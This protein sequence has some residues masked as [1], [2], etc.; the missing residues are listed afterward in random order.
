[1]RLLV[2]TV[3]LMLAA[4]SSATAEE[5]RGG[6]GPTIPQATGDPHPEGNDYMRRNHMKMMRHDRDLT[7]Y[8]GIR[9]AHASIAACFDCH[10]VKDEE[11]IP[12][13][14][15]DERHFCRTCHDFAAVRIDCFDCHRSTPEGVDEP[16][17]HAGRLSVPGREADDSAVL[18]AY[19]DG[20]QTAKTEAQQ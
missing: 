7:M 20:L 8:D 16:E 19:L 9:P 2:L 15:A 17:I 4:V 18:H 5:T 10:A 6:L 14:V 1:M 13:T 12:V 11:G 3:G